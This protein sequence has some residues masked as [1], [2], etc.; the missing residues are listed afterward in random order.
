[1]AELNPIKLREQDSDEADEL[2]RLYFDGRQQ[3]FF[4]AVKQDAPASFDEGW[5][6]T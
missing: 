3:R 6:N 2:A 4:D 5:G 1:V